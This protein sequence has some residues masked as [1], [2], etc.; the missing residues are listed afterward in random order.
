MIR[1]A[2]CG[3]WRP[4]R[5]AG[6]GRDKKKKKKKQSGGK[7]R[8]IGEQASRGYPTWL[9]SWWDGYI[10]FD[11]A[12]PNGCADEEID[13]CTLTNSWLGRDLPEAGAARF[14]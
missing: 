4:R 1:M 14:S 7:P 10:G 9:G 5:S 12:A 3:L 2:A 11:I 13:A 6:R 8:K